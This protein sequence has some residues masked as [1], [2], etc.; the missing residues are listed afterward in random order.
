MDYHSEKII[1]KLLLK[2]LF[3]QIALTEV[4]QYEVLDYYVLSRQ[5][6]P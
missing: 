6:M 1:Q 4:N 3:P 2:I 5:L